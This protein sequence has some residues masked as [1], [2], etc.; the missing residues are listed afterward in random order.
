LKLKKKSQLEL[1][2][3]K[4]HI[5]ITG[6]YI[7]RGAFGGVVNFTLDYMKNINKNKFLYDYFSYGKSPKW[8]KNDIHTTIFT[9]FLDLLISVFRFPYVLHKKKI[10]IVHINAGLTSFSVVRDG[11]FSILAKLMGCKVLFMIHGWKENEYKKLI[12]NPLKRKTIFKLFS[13]QDII[14]V[15]SKENKNKLVDLGLTEN[16]IFLFTNMVEIDKYSNNKKVHETTV[17]ILFCAHPV[18]K[19]KGIDEFIESIPII[20]NQ[21]PFCEFIVLGGGENLEKYSKKAHTLD[22]KN[23]IDFTGFVSKSEKFRIFKK[24]HIL[25]FPSY[26]EGFPKTVL[27]AMAAGMAIVSTPVGGLANAIEPEKNGLFIK[28]MP[29]KPEE[30]ASHVCRILNDK[31]YFSDMMNKNKNDAINKYEAKIVVGKIENKYFEIF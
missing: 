6:L 25:V 27:E 2:Q 28:S 7:G 4:I 1:S 8:C 11:V 17:K 20:I 24:C 10:D 22:L 16:K 15:G 21:Y 30:I 5:L 26:T 3:E 13:N 19:E 14:G 12:E 29:P 18:R 31:K 23:C 9:Y